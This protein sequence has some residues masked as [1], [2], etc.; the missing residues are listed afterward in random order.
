METPE[1]DPDRRGPVLDPE[2]VVSDISVVQD[3]L[4]HFASTGAVGHL[5][6]AILFTRM[7]ISDLGVRAGTG[8][9][10][11]VLGVDAIVANIL[12]F[13]ETFG[14]FTA[15]GEPG[16]LNDAIQLANA[17]LS[18]LQELRRTQPVPADGLEEAIREA[19]EIAAG[20]PAG[21]LGRGR[22]LAGLGV[23]LNQKYAQLGVLGYLEEAIKWGREA[24][25][26]TPPDHPDRGHVLAGLSVFLYNRYA[27]VGTREDLEEPA[28]LAEEAVAA[29]AKDHPERA[30]RLNNLCI[31]LQSRYERFR[32]VE[33]LERAIEAGEE[34]LEATPPGH[35]GRLSILNNLGNF[36]QSRYSRLGRLEDLENGIRRV[37]EA[38]DA[39]PLDH[40]DRVSV[41]QN[42]SD[43]FHLRYSR[44]Q[45]VEDL[46]QA[47]RW[48]EE[49][50]A[51]TPP[52]HSER[53]NRL[54]NLAIYLNSKYT[55]LG[56]L[57]DLQQAITLAGEAA[58]ATPQSHPDR[59]SRLHGLGDYLR[60]RYVRLGALE[61]LEQSIKWAEQAV[62]ATPRGHPD[63]ASRLQN[64]ANS[65]HSKFTRLSTLED[66]QQA[67]KWAEEAVNATPPDDPKRARRLSNLGVF[68]ESKYQRLGAV[69]D[70]EQLIKLVE[71]A[72]AATPSDVNH[73]DRPGILHNL[74]SSLHSRYTRF[75]VVE[76][77]EQAIRRTEEA[78][79]TTPSD[80]PVR[81]KMLHNLSSFLK[82]RYKRSG[83]LK[84]L[85]E[86]IDRA[87]EA[88]EATPP[89]NSHSERA[90]ILSNLGN[91]L[92]NRYERFGALADLEQAIKLAE[93]ALAATP[94]D[95]PDRAGKLNNL[96]NF[97]EDRY[98]RLGAVEDLEQAIKRAE[99]AVAA[100]PSGHSARAGS[101]SNLGIRFHI[102]YER[103]GALGDLEKAIKL[104][105][106]A[107]EATPLDLGHTDRPARLNNLSGALNARYAELGAPRDQEQA[108]KQAEAA[109]EATP[110]N[111]FDRPGILFNLGE[112]LLL[113]NN[114]QRSIETFLKAWYSELS[115]PRYRI[116]AARSAAFAC[117]FLELWQDAASLLEGAVKMLTTISPRFLDRDD[118]E[119][120]LSSRGFTS[121]AADAV[122][123]ALQAGAEP[124]HCLGL[125]ELGRGIIMGLAIDY[126]SDLSELEIKNPEL[127]ARF[128]SL[129]LEIDSPIARDKYQSPE[130]NRR[131]R[132]QAIDRMEETLADIRRLPG[133]GG[134][135]LPPTSVD[136]MAM[137]VEGPIVVLNSTRL[138]S[139]ALIVTSSSIKALAL[140]KL[141]CQEVND[142]M[143]QVGGMVR[144]K[145]S[146]Y[147]A[148]N[149]KMAG[150]LLWL[151]DAA[152]E[153]VLEELKLDVDSRIWW[154]GVGPL[155]MAPF[156]AA[157]DHSPGSTR[158]TLH[159][160]ISSYIPTIKALSYAREKE[161][162]L[163]S[164][165]S[166]L[167]LVTMATTPGNKALKN[168]TQEAENIIFMVGDRAT[169]LDRPSTASVMEKLPSHHAIHF[170][171][172]GVSDPINP[173]NSHLLLLNDD[174]SETVDRLTVRQIASTNLKNAQLAYLSACS[175]ADNASFA[176]ADES[177]H[178]ASGF[179]LAGF[180]H[181]LAT[182]WES[183]DI[184]CRQVAGEFYSLLFDVHRHVE[185]HRKVGTA[186]HHAVVSL[187]NQNPTQ[188]LK[189]ACFIH[190]GA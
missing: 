26:E 106:E 51:A 95:R 132:V 112:E 93:E 154:I 75:G 21:D 72:L 5:D 94:P 10:D 124:A 64:L 78:L 45:A 170:A 66:L 59:A 97:L 101:L 8:S 188:P 166:R 114:F 83:V 103:F 175:T 31:F 41:L 140:P 25:E 84:D 39:T 92:Y 40:P 11:P 130:Q 107:L 16:H 138:R 1:A 165:D 151:W 116:L 108:I 42:L 87:E 86:S 37:R 19:G 148:R 32:A 176:L 141:I 14:R 36:L 73:P 89:E 111:H 147:P 177:I 90:A 115:P 2:E 80:H 187:R 17:L 58:T 174:G 9:S 54:H 88:L 162:K 126:R 24:V 46:V 181:V 110:E 48:A 119:H 156:H 139:D 118:Q 167:L 74:A 44:F 57:E 186:F 28:R 91:R 52:D 85:D 169:R 56:A 53:A 164:G 143:R 168:A 65:H 4:G 96:G 109:A 178:I 63:R 160:A 47:I 152:V 123:V 157:G 142:W 145:R 127:F 81:A 125:L 117:G 23:G 185:G 61:D 104:A 79:E 135:Q 189:W 131:S 99:E 172:H 180:S 13:Q 82:D 171:C 67:I 105:Q 153:P 144:G 7:L 149:K 120:V 76:D 15:T 179:Q 35:P 22:V 3:S 150:L 20:T 146:T 69:E 27:H 128:S 30:G 155:A 38:A 163:L 190:T 121:L 137:A 70:L 33:D 136:L 113:S 50:L 68:L 49:V 29:T 55:R 159:R 134:F 100:A 98:T 129:R 182:L 102:K 34:A 6:D 60:Q 18:D 77:L 161:L 71:E 133:F 184:A 158:N 62:A 173:S 183:N 43:S 12:V 122:A